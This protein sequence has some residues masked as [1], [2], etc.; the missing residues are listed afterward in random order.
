MEAG[1]S[2]RR[3]GEKQNPG[4]IPE[5]RGGSGV[6]TTSVA[7]QRE[8]VNT[9]SWPEELLDDLEASFS[10]ERLGTY[11]TVAQ[12]DREQALKLYTRNTQLSAAFYGPL[13]G[14]EI[15]LRNALHRELTRLY[16]EAW[17]DQPAAGL[18]LGALERIVTAKAKIT[19]AGGTV[20]PSGLV[21]GF[22][23]GFWVSLL[24][25]GGR[26]DPAGRRAN[27]EMTLWRP[28]LRPR[29]R[30]P[31]A[32]DAHPCLSAAERAAEAAQPD[33]PSRAD[34]RE[35]LTRRPP[36][37]PGGDRLDFARGADVDRAPQPRP[38]AARRLGRRG[39]RPLLRARARHAH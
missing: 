33:R 24:G 17:Y 23:F 2:S 34:L 26:L 35:T 11:L 29:V 20:P 14:L 15:A 3:T 16:G 13:Q 12:G 21:A 4:R 22:S 30:A 8:A 37:H 18:D 28:G 27:Y 19:R 10:R 6:Y 32:A 31:H 38:H 39:G 7:R 5:G 25:P 36:A 1:A 9:W